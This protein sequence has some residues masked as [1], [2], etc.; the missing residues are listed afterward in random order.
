VNLKLFCKNLGGVLFANVL[1]GCTSQ[2]TYGDAIA[3]E[4]KD[5]KPDIQSQPQIQGKSPPQT[6]GYT[7]FI[8][9]QQENMYKTLVAEIAILRGNYIL[10][11][12]YFFDV[13]LKVRDWQL[14]HRA[15]QA[16][17]YAKRYD[18]ATQAALLWVSISPNDLNARKILANILLSQK[19]IDETV[20]HLEA[21]FDNLKD[22][23]QQLMLVMEDILEPKNPALAFE[24]LEKLVAKRPDNPVVLLI[25][26]RFLLQAKKVEQAKRVL[27]TLLTHVPY[28]DDAVPLYAYV[29]DKLEKTEQALQWLEQAVKKYPTKQEWRL[30]YARML[31]DAEQFDKAIKQFQQL[32][33]KSPKN[34]GDILYALGVLSLQKKQRSAAT[35]YFMRLLETGERLNTARYYL[36][37]IAQEEKKLDK[38]L[39]WYYQM[40]EGSNYLNAQA[41]IALILAEQGNLDKAIKHLRQVPVD[42]LEDKTNLIQMEAELLIDE[43][44]YQ[45]ALEAYNHALE[46]KQDDIEILYMRALLYEKMDKLNLLERDLRRVLS[47]AP[48]NVGALNALGYSLA[49]RT[50]RYQEAY[51]LIN[52]ALSLSPT[53][54]Y[55]LDSMGWVLYRMGNHVDAIAYLRKARAQN[56]DIEIAAHLGVVLCKTG[57][58]QAAKEVWKEAQKTFPDDEI[59]RKIVRRECQIDLKSY[60]G[61]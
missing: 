23:P 36:G 26:S 29:L 51:E 53:D 9:R 22:H 20:V 35:D 43:K 42:S 33:S 55:I 61:E 17:L 39:H 57:D 50:D 28:H 19:R 46:L 49:D 3:Q 52:K 14:A 8:S 60:H 34:N 4:T 21:L 47:I 48:E 45:Q 59:L 7:Y 32:L 12:T 58:E 6:I 25:Y 15:T 37:L 41:R 5:S 1:M 27:Q 16:A 13:A 24:L 38:A 31:A 30:M 54:Y 2:L 11:A 44:R 18:M 40:K 10:A 56:D